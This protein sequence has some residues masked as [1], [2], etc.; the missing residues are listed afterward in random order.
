MDRELR[1]RGIVLAEERTDL[2]VQRTMIAALIRLISSTIRSRTFG[3][4]VAP[5]TFGSFLNTATIL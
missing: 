2:A 3:I 1:G 4:L 5:V